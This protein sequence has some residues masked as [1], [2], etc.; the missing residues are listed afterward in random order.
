ME[1]LRQAVRRK[2][3]GA[4]GLGGPR[5]RLATIEYH[6][7]VPGIRIAIVGDFEPKRDSHVATEAAL[8]HAADALGVHLAS[9]WL[10]T[11]TFDDA[12]RARVA[13]QGFDGVWCAPG[14]PYRSLEGAL[15]AIRRTREGDLPLLATCGGFQHV[16]LEY[17]RN[18]IGLEGVGHAEYHIGAGE[19]LI[20]PLGD[21][22]AGKTLPVRLM[23]GSAVRQYYGLD[24]VEEVYRCNYGLDDRYRSLLEDD[25]LAVVG[26]DTDGGVR[27]VTLPAKQFF[28]ATLFLPQLSS[29][30]ERPHPL[31]RAFVEVVA[32]SRR[33]QV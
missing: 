21:V 1:A 2:G 14:S 25:G 10:A 16:V 27:L 26:W 17:A 32:G 15:N 13:L 7:L 11:P 4:G 31:V 23:P 33:P 20:A 5:C 29:S 8:R 9:K 28:V 6:G 24:E 30:A 12:S 3:L 19:C 22:V 18:V